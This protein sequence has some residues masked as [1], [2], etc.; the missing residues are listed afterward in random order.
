M[1][2]MNLRNL[3]RKGSWVP[4]LTL[5]FKWS[6]P[7]ELERDGID[8]EDKFGLTLTKVVPLCIVATPV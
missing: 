5:E 6:L 4:Q 7:V 2:G 3:C 1:Y 8:M